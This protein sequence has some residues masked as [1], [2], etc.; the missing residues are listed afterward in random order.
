MTAP[1]I[2]N[3]LT[4][5]ANEQ[6][7]EQGVLRLEEDPLP[8]AYGQALIRLYFKGTMPSLLSTSGFPVNTVITNVT[9]EHQEVLFFQ[10]SNTAAFSRPVVSQARVSQVGRFL[11]LQGR[12]IPSVNLTV[13]ELTGQVV[14]NQ[15]CYG[16]VQTTYRSTYT[17]L[18]CAYQRLLD[19]AL[20]KSDFSPM[21]IV[22]FNSL[23]TR[24][25]LALEPPDRLTGGG[26]NGFDRTSGE[27]LI[28]ELDPKFPV[29]LS[30][31]DA[32]SRLT[33]V[34]RFFVYSYGDSVALTCT[35]G[36]ITNT[37]R[38]ETLEMTEGISFSGSQS[39][40]VKYPPIRGISV[41]AQGSF[42]SKFGPPFSP[43]FV[44]GPGIVTTVDWIGY[45]Q[46]RLT[47]NRDVQANEV[48]VT[49]GGSIL[50]PST[51]LARARYST[52]RA[53]YTLRWTRP[54]NDWFAP[55]VVLASDSQGRT[56]TTTINPPTRR[57]V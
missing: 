30:H 45:Q 17:R 9:S 13:N 47:G 57:G 23:G 2:T 34:A 50:I 26:Y 20:S 19:P 36:S 12:L 4:S 11:D 32:R 3:V 1:V 16:T 18:Q 35:Q 31:N 54:A 49:T 6:Q 51:G 38:A 39:T 44:V 53:S 29:S 5:Y 37:T 43:R 28:I 55:V 41:T 48:A 22:A 33:A 25:S 27:Q 21:L 56:G 52:R 24:A 8:A 40:S 7:Y 42:Q 14:A 46:Y 15:P 10:G